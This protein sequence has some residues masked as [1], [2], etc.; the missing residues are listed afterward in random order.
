V[1]LAVL[2]LKQCTHPSRCTDI[3]DFIGIVGTPIIDPSTSIVYFFSKGYKNGAY[4]G[5]VANGILAQ[6]L[7]KWKLIEAGIYSFYAVDIN[8][9]QDIPGF[10]ILIDGHFA[11]ND[12][13]R[14]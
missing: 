6:S 8:T 13:A 10:P 5:G 1:S 14:Y 3:P 12:N 2:S 4:S 7:L 9:L 11:D